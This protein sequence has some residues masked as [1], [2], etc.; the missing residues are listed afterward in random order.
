MI[1]QH[2]LVNVRQTNHTPVM[3][4]VSVVV[5]SSADVLNASTS[6]AKIFVADLMYVGNSLG[7]RFACVEIKILL[8][9][10]AESSRRPP[11]H[12]R[13]ACSMAWRC[14]FLTARPSQDGRV[15]AKIM[16]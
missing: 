2:V 14:R 10:H 4:G 5:A 13:D 6:S 1:C 15:I 9:V 12:R 3:V 8:R 7:H 16:T 11:R